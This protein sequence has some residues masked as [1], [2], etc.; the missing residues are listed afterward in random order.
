METEMEVTKLKVLLKGRYILHVQPIIILVKQK[1]EGRALQLPLGQLTLE[2]ARAVT[3][4]ITVRK[5]KKTL[6]K[7]MEKARQ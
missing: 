1:G 3:A 7:D 4:V 2:T 5:K 6:Q